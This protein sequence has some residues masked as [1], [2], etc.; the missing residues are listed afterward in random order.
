MIKEA[1][2]PTNQPSDIK[3]DFYSHQLKHHYTFVLSSCK[4]ITVEPINDLD[5]PGLL[6]SRHTV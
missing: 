1:G 4:V 6:I 2:W 3:H 5:H